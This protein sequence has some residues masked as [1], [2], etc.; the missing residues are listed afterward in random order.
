MTEA[1][2]SNQGSEKGVFGNPGQQSGQQAK[3]D[4]K[5]ASTAG[6]KDGSMNELPTDI[7]VRLRRLDKL[8][9]RYQGMYRYD[10]AV[11]IP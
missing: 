8:E 11:R 2:S 5:E 9:A 1:S 6:L 3:G 7:R 10:S 4:A